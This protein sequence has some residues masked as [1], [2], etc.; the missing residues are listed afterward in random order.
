MATESL[1]LSAL[2]AM[3]LQGGGEMGELIR[4][5]DWSRTGLGPVGDWSP[6]LRTAA[7]ICLGSKFPSA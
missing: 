6:S 2:T 7:S 1:H 4:A 3:W 5:K